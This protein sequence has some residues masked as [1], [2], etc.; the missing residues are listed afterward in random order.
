M[1]LVEAQLCFLLFGKHSCAFWEA[2]P[3]FS[4]VKST[5]MLHREA[6]LYF[7]HKCASREKK[8]NTK[9]FHKT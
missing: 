8:Q 3:C 5:P 7:F 2:Q 4:K 6:Q 1:L 9:F